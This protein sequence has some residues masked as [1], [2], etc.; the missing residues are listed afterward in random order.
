MVMLAKPL[1]FEGRL[2]DAA[3]TRD[4]NPAIWLEGVVR[5]A[6]GDI[7]FSEVRFITEVASGSLWRRRIGA[8][9]ATTD[10]DGSGR[11]GSVKR[12]IVED[13]GAVRLY[14]DRVGAAKSQ[15]GPVLVFERAIAETA[16]H[17][18]AIA[19]RLY[20]EARFT[21]PVVMGV[22]LNGLAGGQSIEFA[23]RL[24]DMPPLEEEAYTREVRTDAVELLANPAGVAKRLVDDLMEALTQRRYDPF[25]G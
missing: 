8:W 2:A 6:Q 21:G 4:T 16:A 19:G 13:D 17:F 22:G 12:L 5:A 18:C 20:A 15:D 7:P 9:A 1:G 14:L 24:Q 23:Q 11:P 25:A 3:P 10:V